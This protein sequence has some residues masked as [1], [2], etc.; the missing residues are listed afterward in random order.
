[1]NEVTIKLTVRDAD[2]ARLNIET[3]YWLLNGNEMRGIDR[4][5]LIGI[6]SILTLIAEDPQVL[7]EESAC[8]EARKKAKEEKHE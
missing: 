2:R 5:R 6:I 3:C 4:D 7:A 1:M 8:I